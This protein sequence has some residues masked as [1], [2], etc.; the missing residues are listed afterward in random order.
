[1]KAFIY[2]VLSNI[3]YNK[4]IYFKQLVG[5]DGAICSTTVPIIN[6]LSTTNFACTSGFCLCDSSIP[7]MWDPNTRTCI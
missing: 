6:C 7:T 1:M 3:K 5:L 4:M 2:F